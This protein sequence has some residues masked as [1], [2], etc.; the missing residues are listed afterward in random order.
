[1]KTSRTDV[2][3]TLRAGS[4]LIFLIALANSSIG[5][6]NGRNSVSPAAPIA[7]PAGLFQEGDRLRRQGEY[8]KSATVLSQCLE[9]SRKEGQAVLELDSLLSLGLVYWNTG[10]LQ[11][12]S[13]YYEKALALA[14]K[15]SDKKKEEMSSAFLKIFRLY[16]EGKDFRSSKQL[17][18]AINRF[19]EAIALSREIKSP[20]HEAKCLRQFS[21]LYWDQ[22]DYKKFFKLNE[23]AVKLSI[24]IGNKKEEG[25]CLNNLGL[26]YWKI[27]NYASA[28]SSYEA[29]LE[30]AKKEKNA[31]DQAD[32][33]HNMGII[34]AYLGNYEKALDHLTKAYNLD[35]KLFDKANLAKDYN[36]IG[37]AFI[38]KGFL[39]DNKEDFN[40]ALS[41]F[42]DSLKLAKEAK[43][44]KLIIQVLNNIGSAKSHQQLYSEALEYLELALSQAKETNDNNSLGM[45]LNNIGIV[46]FNR[47]NY[48][49]STRYYQKAIDVALGINGGDILWEAYLEIANSLKNQKR[50]EEAINN[51]ENSIRV[52]EE[53]R[54]N[55][56][57]EELKASYLGSEKR[58]DAYQNL[59]DL[60]ATLDID[61]NEKKHGI[62]AFN[63]L[64]KA[65]AR[66]FLD[67]LEVSEVNVSQGVNFKL[68]NLEK[69]IMREISQLYTKLLM[70]GLIPED[71]ARITEQLKTFEEKLDTLKREIRT[72]SPAYAGLKY[73]EI[74]SLD[75]AKRMADA[76]TAFFAYTVGKDRSYGFVLR[77]DDF[78][79]FRAPARK[80]L[81]DQVAEYRKAI[82][83]KD[84]RDFG[85]GRV[86]FEEL[87]LPGLTK[88]TKRIVFVPDDI[89]N[90]LPFETLISDDRKERW[91]V[92][93]YAIAYVPSLSSLRELNIRKKGLRSQPKKDLLAFG[94]PYYGSNEEDV[95]G[96][97]SD[98]FQD[99]Y[100]N[101]SL[102]FFRLKY[103]GL[104]T[105][106]I[107][108]LFKASRTDA[109]QRENATEDRLKSEPLTDYRIIH[110]ATHGLIDDKKP[111]RSSI[112]LSLDQDP[113]E[114]G[115][116]QMREVF[117]LKMN[118]D[119]VV[120]SA[121][122]TGLGQFIRGEGIE[123]MS[124][125]FFYAGSSSVLMSLW[126]VNDQATYQ[127]MERFYRHLKSSENPMNALRR[128]K[129]EMIGSKVLSHPY[130][131]AGFILNGKTD[132][133]IFP[134]PFK[135]WILLASSVCAGIMI[136][137]AFRTWNRKKS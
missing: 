112:I 118:A 18:M 70:P 2:K 60:L 105:R 75:E 22:A 80:V 49:E 47:G 117:D 132:G 45:L 106:G 67:S 8:D 129:L 120:L 86:L 116:L 5:F 37:M 6:Q 35:Q 92:Q 102:N 15:V 13:E 104:E 77:K 79:I 131:W 97:G 90:L 72:T 69:E 39:S 57:Q 24:S 74:I 124:R 93:D 76:G 16:Q 23:L 121:C 43:D 96:Q 48:E 54:Y 50:Y 34:W 82:S 66:G 55:S 71:K 29:S 107:A 58:I 78:R 125:A 20:D 51:Y 53:I 28:L 19:Q 14:Q 130:Y 128:A 136:L 10:K 89:L 135:R 61:D 123:G 114:D 87:V 133:I 63:Y 46:Y 56:V 3:R 103:S 26:Y 32:T 88:G 111:A 73:P 83:D 134:S 12:S 59:I 27:D 127:L 94:D 81:Q 52:I 84:N 98:I 119:L 21:V 11:E 115:F 33:L 113:A 44:K 4:L 1:M 9:V 91:L 25:R 122:Q 42:S 7:S 126:A 17:N 110:F 99:F 68:V 109:F 36:T 41:Y 62:E 101:P 38:K 64:E 95:R 30:I 40:K 65:K 31:L 85:L 137:L 100:S 108:S